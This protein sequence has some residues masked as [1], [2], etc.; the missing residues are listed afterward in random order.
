[1]ARTFRAF[2]SPVSSGS[3]FA[4]PLRN[5]TRIL[6]TVISTD[7]SGAWVCAHDCVV[8]KPRRQ[9]KRATKPRGNSP[10]A[11]TLPGEGAAPARGHLSGNCR[12]HSDGWPRLEVQAANPRPPTNQRGQTGGGANRPGRS[13]PLSRWSPLRP[14]LGDPSSPW[15]GRPQPRRGRAG[16]R[17]LPSPRPPRGPQEGTGERKNPA[18]TIPHTHTS[19]GLWDCEEP[20]GEDARPLSL[21]R[22]LRLGSRSAIQQPPSWNLAPRHHPYVTSYP[23][24]PEISAFPG[25][26]KVECNQGLRGWS[27]FR[28]KTELHWLVIR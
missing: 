28:S 23:R 17:G 16:L 3:C 14:R 13:P 22:G 5:G 18:G 1:M 7:D 11:E 25:P 20:G 27:R 15:P 26:G 12:H 19:A 4:S 21:R 8:F 10:Q 9:G 6:C 2:L 24:G